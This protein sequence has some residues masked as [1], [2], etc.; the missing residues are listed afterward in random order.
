VR[1]NPHPA[2]AGTDLSAWA[3]IVGAGHASAG[4]PGDAVDGVI[5]GAVVCP[6]TIPEVQD[7]VRAGGALVATGLG[8]HQDMGAPPRALDALVR[9]DRLA[10]VVDHQAADMTVTLEAGCSLAT[11]DA[12]L[13]T[14]G[15]WLPLDPP[16]FGNTTV[17]GL[18]A[19]NLSGPLRA[20]QG[21]VRDLLLGITVV[22]GDGGLVHG[23][24]R[25]V[26]NVAGYDLPKLHVGAL[27]TLGI[28]VE[29]TFKVRPR[30]EREAAAILSTP[31]AAETALAVRGLLDP[32]W[33]EAGTLD[34]GEGVAIGIGGIDAELAEAR[35]RLEGLAAARGLELAWI[36]DGAALRRALGGFGVEPCAAALR[37]S[38]LPADV[39]WAIARIRAVAGVIPVLA[40]VAS[41]VVRARL[42]DDARAPEV[43]RV[44]RGE[45]ESR[46][47]FLVV[48]R[49]RPSVKRAVDPWGNPGEG[50]GLMRAVKA[51][52]DPR[53]V[54]APGRYV[55]GI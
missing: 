28:I 31:A 1:G 24:G 50:L 16:R 47:G 17:G 48:E 42:D 54:F 30:P 49:A 11:L 55:G 39:P 33:L 15:Q 26:K 40:Q 41:G 9:L 4:T 12:V 38:V 27:G 52:L 43:A 21:T 44:V 2:P 19:A 32:L 7:I 8:A 20:S 46:G 53:G 51:A 45:I 37:A 22:G 6:G 34:D 35:R 23:G 10:R 5:P 13:A 14:A 36:T 3:D 18:V 25:V 29:A